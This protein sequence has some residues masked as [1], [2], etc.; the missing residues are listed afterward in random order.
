MRLIDL[1]SPVDAS[2]WEPDPVTHTIMSPADGAQHMQAEMRRHFG[3]DFPAE[4]LPDG[5]FLNLD[6]LTLT[7]H[8][9]THV[10]APS[11]YGSRAAYGDGPP[12]TI[13]QL[14]LEWFE[15]PGFVID[16][17]GVGTC[18]ASA[19][20][21]AAA[22]RRIAYSPSP[23]DIA[24]IK[25]GAEHRVGTPSYFTEFAGLDGP[26]VHLLLDLGIRVIGTDAFSLDAPFPH[27]LRAFQE[28]GDRGVL[29]PA[30]FAG[31]TREYCQVERLANLDQLP[32]DSGFRVSCFPVK[33]AGAGPAGP[34]PWPRWV[35]NSSGGAARAPGS[36][37]AAGPASPRPG[38]NAGCGRTPPAR[39]AGPGP[40]AANTAGNGHPQATHLLLARRGPRS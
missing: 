9:G 39:S 34:G 31:R 24:L 19:A 16:L 11:H 29:W 8:T 2:F 20:Q 40:G 1:S 30:H 21:V 6:T 10:D 13:D 26:A 38:R 36:A 35:T 22:L 32:T 5:E 37:S 33:I 23:G 12:R 25:T 7:T 28:T 15:G 27:I 14:P 3:I 17:I 4:V 18:A